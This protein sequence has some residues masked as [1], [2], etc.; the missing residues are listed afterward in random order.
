[1]LT[2]H[3]LLYSTKQNQT[4]QSFPSQDVLYAMQETPSEPWLGSVLF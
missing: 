1:M 2:S 3:G 4:K